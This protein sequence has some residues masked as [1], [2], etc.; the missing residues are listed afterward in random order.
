[1]FHVTDD[2]ELIAR[3]AVGCLQPPPP[4]RPTATV[5]GW[6]L[7]DTCRWY[8]FRVLEFDDSQPRATIDCQVVD[9]GR[10]RDFLGFNR[11]RHAVLEAAILA[12]RVQWLS[13]DQMFLRD[14]IQSQL[15]TEAGTRWRCADEQSAES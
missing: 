4:C 10:V 3:S 5:E 6:I 14:Y 2:V 12:T 8:A 15:D 9:S 1:V 13:R 11:A 7:E